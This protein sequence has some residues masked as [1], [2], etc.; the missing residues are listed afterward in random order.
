MK[1]GICLESRH[2]HAC[3]PSLTGHSTDSQV[4]GLRS[5]NLWHIACFDNPMLP[6]CHACA[7]ADYDRLTTHT[8]RC[9]TQC[10]SH[11]CPTSLPYSC[12]HSSPL[13]HPFQQAP[14][15]APA[16]PALQHT[17]TSSHPQEHMECGRAV[18]ALHGLSHG[19]GLHATYPRFN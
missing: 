16:E 7:C 5:T 15:A 1:S 2:L 3:R 12:W 10:P 11:L 18:G 19:P 14:A 13:S 8:C 6:V 4:K 17:S 9:P